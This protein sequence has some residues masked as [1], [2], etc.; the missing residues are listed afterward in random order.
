[1]ARLRIAIVVVITALAALLLPAPSHA[2]TATQMTLTAPASVER[3]TPYTLSGGLLGGVTG[4]EPIVGVTVTL[5][6]T[7][8]AGSRTVYLKTTV[9]GFSYQD[10]PAVGGLV[11][12][13]ATWPGTLDQTAAT[14]SRT[15]KV[16]RLNPSMSIRTD[17]TIYGYGTKATVTVHLGKTWNNREVQLFATRI[18]TGKT[19]LVAKGRVNSSGNLTATYGMASKTVFVVKFLGD[20]RYAPTARKATVNVRPKLIMSTYMSTGHSGS[21]W[22]ASKTGKISVIA[23]IIPTGIGSC[24]QWVLQEYSGGAWRTI[25]GLTCA[26]TNWDS[27]AVAIITGD[28]KAGRLRINCTA[29]ANTYRV[30]ATS[31]WVYV[32]FV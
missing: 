3:A 28:G 6:R 12:W 5:I 16:S 31:P 8:L 1:M 7:D 24:T 11:T 9:D 32:T 22:Y 21:V 26:K 19:V 10:S 25:D 20:Y 30:A 17:A 23:T 13:K 27:Q 18:R 14:A 4:T 15:V 2:A 29:P